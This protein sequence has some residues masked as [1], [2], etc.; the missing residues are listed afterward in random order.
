MNKIL[1]T[2]RI[3]IITLFISV[4]IIISSVVILDFRN[5]QDDQEIANLDFG[6]GLSIVGLTISIELIIYII[7]SLVNKK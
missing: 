6:F 3:K 2:K 7:Y 1:S 5:K 4:F